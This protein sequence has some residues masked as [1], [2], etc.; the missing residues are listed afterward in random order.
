MIARFTGVRLRVPGLLLCVGIATLASVLGSRMPIVGG[1]VFGI[2][3][4]VVIA[5]L[6]PAA[7]DPRWQPGVAFASKQVLQVAI[8]LLGATLNL[9]VIART[10]SGSLPVMLGTLA[11]C[12]GAAAFIGR[13]FALDRTL[14]VMI[15]VGTA[16]CGASAIAAISS[17][18]DAEEPDISYA[19][20]TVF[21]YNIAAVLVFPA[22]GH[23]LALSQPAFA[24]WAGTAINDT[25]SVV[26]AAVAY[27]PTAANEAIVVKLTR[28]LLIVPIVIALALRHAR[29]TS[30]SGGIAWKSVLPLFI[31]W[32]IAGAI[33]NTIGIIPASAHAAISTTAVFLIILALAGVGL[34]SDVRRLRAAGVRPNLLGAVLWLLVA[35]SSLLLQRLTGEF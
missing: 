34:S 16:I 8:V 6:V 13:W 35:S 1:S 14:Q 25:S 28:M 32:F 19:I 15:G 3:L 11:I 27:G 20:S 21:L 17:V 7:S 30:A 12:L 33:L 26:A 5:A 23:L 10:S 18:I 22:L 2:V 24:L 31:V 29:T 9:T 4:G